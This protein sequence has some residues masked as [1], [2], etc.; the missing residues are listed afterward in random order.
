MEAIRS[1][2]RIISHRHSTSRKVASI[3]FA[4]APPERYNSECRPKNA[5]NNVD[6]VRVCVAFPKASSGNIYIRRCLSILRLAPANLDDCV[7]LR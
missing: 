5:P 7:R 4:V 2:S 1:A 6:A 3:R